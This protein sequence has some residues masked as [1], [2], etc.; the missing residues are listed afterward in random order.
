MDEPTANTLMTRAAYC[1]KGAGDYPPIIDTQSFIK[2][3]KPLRIDGPGGVL[4][5]LPIAQEHGRIGSLGFRIGDL[6][7][8]NDLNALPSKSIKALKGIEI[9]IV[10]ALRY[11]AHPSHLNVS[12]AIAL[13]GEIGA[14]RTI[15]T[16]MHIDLDYQTLRKEL[17]ESIEPGYDGMVIETSS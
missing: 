3:F 1:F 17:P 4:S 2:P 7:Y 10:D 8:C 15:L 5:I 9:L 16:N 6:A 14:R 13:S 12:E 11:T